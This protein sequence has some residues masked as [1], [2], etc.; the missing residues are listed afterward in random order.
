MVLKPVYALSLL[1][2]VWWGTF[3]P[4]AIANPRVTI[5]NRT[6]L[7]ITQ[8]GQTHTLN[9]RDWPI[10]L[11]DATDCANYATLPQRVVTGR[12]ISAE[13][14]I[15]PQSGQ[16]AI[17]VILT[18]CA[19][20]QQSAVFILDPQPDG[21]IAYRAPL[22]GPRPLPD[23]FSSYGFSSVLGLQYWDGNLLV[24]HGSADGSEAMII[25]TRG[26]SPAG[27]YAGCVQLQA[28]EG[29][30]GCPQISGAD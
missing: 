13:P 17:G 18:E 8:G 5:Q 25:F 14:A 19:D 2:A 6:Q 22:P 9:V 11:L 3:A 26:E 21:Y 16:I 10:N 7:T 15:D 30:G 28:G 29:G 23:A 1:A 12:M 20:V 27:I 24:R 4:A